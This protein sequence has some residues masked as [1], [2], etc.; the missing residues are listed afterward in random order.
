MFRQVRS[1]F[2]EQVTLEISSPYLDPVLLAD[3]LG[4]P[5]ENWRGGDDAR[6]FAGWKVFENPRQSI[7]P[8]VACR[9]HQYFAVSGGR[10]SH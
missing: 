5:P 2:V 10:D 9:L 3:Q 6:S 7:D 8:A 1:S 4:Y